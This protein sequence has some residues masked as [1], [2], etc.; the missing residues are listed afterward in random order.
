MEDRLLR[1]HYTESLVLRCRSL[2]PWYE[3]V[4]S[5]LTCIDFATSNN[6]NDSLHF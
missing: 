6:H 5:S 4:L 2:E 3:K 1:I